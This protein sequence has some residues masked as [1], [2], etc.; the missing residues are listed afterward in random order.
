MVNV[1]LPTSAVSAVD[2]AGKYLATP[3][4]IT[5]WMMKTMILEYQTA[6]NVY[7]YAEFWWVRLSAQVYLTLQDFE[8]CGRLLKEAWMRVENVNWNAVRV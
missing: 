3:D 5:Q 2:A 1:R 7:Y 4:R 8:R 6:V